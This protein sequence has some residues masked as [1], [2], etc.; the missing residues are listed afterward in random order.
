MVSHSDVF[1]EAADVLPVH[2]VDSINANM[3]HIDALAEH[4]IQ[5]EDDMSI[6]KPVSKSDF[7]SPDGDVRLIT[8]RERYDEM[9]RHVEGLMRRGEWPPAGS[10]RCVY[11]YGE[12]S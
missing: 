6:L 5:I 8:S 3:P 2:N 10:S 11:L 1:G 12:G 9:A 4:F 7:F